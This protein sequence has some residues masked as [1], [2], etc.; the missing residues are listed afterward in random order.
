MPNNDKLIELRKKKTAKQQKAETAKHKELLGAINGLGDTFSI[1]ADK[2][3]QAIDKLLKELGNIGAFKQD[4][5]AVR[6]AIENIPQTDSIKVNN[7]SE[8]IN[9]IPKFDVSEIK[10]ALEKLTTT[11]AEQTADEVAISNTKP[12]DFIPTRRVRL[13]QGRLVYDDDPLKVNVVGGGSRVINNYSKEEANDVRFDPDETAP[14]YIGTHQTQNA[15]TTSTAWYISKFT[16][17]G[18]D[19]ATRIQRRKGSWDNR[20]AGW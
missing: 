19:K 13:V 9:A 6:N 1:N 10:E 18:N 5:I 7:L 8:L 11:V 2:D 12:E 15:P 4:V 14:L 3:S 20:A 16:R 17:D